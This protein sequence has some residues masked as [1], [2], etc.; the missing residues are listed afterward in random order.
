MY[1]EETTGEVSAPKEEPAKVEKQEE[2]RP[3]TPK[4][5]TPRVKVRDSTTWESQAL[6]KIPGQDLQ[7]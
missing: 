5:D 7:G 3:V 2:E 1:V 4:E 6:K